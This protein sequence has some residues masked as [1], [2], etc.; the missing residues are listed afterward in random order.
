MRKLCLPLA[1]ILLAAGTGG[2]GWSDLGA[3]TD[4]QGSSSAFCRVTTTGFPLRLLVKPQ[5]NIYFE[6]DESS[7]QVRSNVPPFEVLYAYE[8]DDVSYDENFSAAGWFRVGASLDAPEGWMRADDVVPWKQAL[9]L[10]FTNP[11][12]SE[13]KPVVMFDSAESLDYAIEDFETAQKDPEQ[14]VDRVITGGDI[15]EGVISREG[16]GWID[17]DQTFY[18]MPILSHLDLSSLGVGYDMRGVQLAALTNQARSAQSDACDIRDKGAADCFRDQQGSGVA[19]LAMEAVFVIDMTAS[20]GPYIDAVRNAVRE[21]TQALAQQ[22]GTDQI[23]FGLVGY[24]DVIHAS[25]GIEFVSNNFTP[26]LLPPVEFSEMLKSGGSGTENSPAIAEATVGSGDY[27]E[28]VFAGLET[29]INSAWSEDVAR[30]IILIGD[31]SSHPLEHEKNT[32]GLDEVSIREMA[33]QADIYIASIYVGSDTDSDFALAKPQF[34]TLA[35]GSDGSRA[36]S[37]AS[38]GSAEALELSMRAVIEAV[39][40]AI[41]GGSFAPIMSSAVAGGDATAGAVLSAVR[42]AFVDYLGG[43]AQPPANIVAWALD[44][45]ITDYSKKSFDLKIMLTRKDMEELQDLVRG[46]I[47]ELNAGSTSSVDFFSG[48]Q[49]ASGA[50]SYDFAI[51]DADRFSNSPNLPTWINALPY[52]SQF[53]SLSREDFVQASPDD[54]SRYE[55]DLKA[56]V[57]LYDEALNRPDGWVA[58]NAQARVDE[59]IYMLDLDNLP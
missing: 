29:A 49:G 14:F 27:A 8:M 2:P 7:A 45:D 15:P 30:V 31:A 19:H 38:G 5:S 36:F 35:A 21:S 22:V 18:L 46:L 51:E 17:I 4:C 39:N 40:A 23:R 12:P 43:D 54:R 1:T 20:M 57:D 56:L 48:I 6:K 28:E 42:A 55:A 11:G 9:A 10:A 3:E 25:P 41:S 24:R 16:S 59:K 32:T 13:R 58:L 37:V 34:E 44:R 50:S 52:K 53:L 33:D 47:S 26:E